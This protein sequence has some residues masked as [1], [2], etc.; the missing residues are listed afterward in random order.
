MTTE[1]EDLVSKMDG[2]DYYRYILKLIKLGE[3]ALPAVQAGMGHSNWRIRRACAAVID[4]IY[5]AESLQRLILLTHDPKKKVRKMAV[6]SIGCDRCK[7][8]VNPIDA[9]P[10]LAYSALN[11]PAVRV[12]K[13]AADMLAIQSPERRVA[14]ILR[15]VIATEEDPRVVRNAE[16][17]LKRHEKLL[18]NV[19]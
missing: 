8:G 1:S 10:H 11:D 13:T 4:H 19:S 14:R 3:P 15:E 18:T 2:R 16:F 6:H 12:R 17:G 9:V 7:D 5:D